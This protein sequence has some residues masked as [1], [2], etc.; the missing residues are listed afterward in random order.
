MRTSVITDPPRRVAAALRATVPRRTQPLPRPRAGSIHS[1][2]HRARAVNAQSIGGENHVQ[3]AM[4][5]KEARAAATRSRA[6][7]DRK[8][9]APAEAARRDVTGSA[10]RPPG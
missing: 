9:E 6:T 4:R 5:R 10:V 3:A 8:P 7:D 2:R 1:I